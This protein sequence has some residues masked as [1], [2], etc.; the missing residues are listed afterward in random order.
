MEKLEAALA[1]AR[2]AR[3]ASL[4]DD[5]AAPLA[6]RQSEPRAAQGGADW[7]AL[8]ELSITTEQARSGRLG[9]LLGGKDATPY[10]MLRSRTIRLMKDA[11]W[12]R[13]AVTSP[14]AACGKTTVSLNLALSL[15]RQRDLRVMLID[16]DLRRPALH[17][18]IGYQP[19]RSFHEVLEEKANVVE[20][21]VRVG[22]NLIIATN[23]TPS[24]HPAEVLHSDRSR[25]VL[26]AIEAAWQPDIMIFDMS[27][28]LASDDNVG[29]LGN[30]DCSLL[31]VAAESTTLPNIDVCEKEL[32]QLTNVLGVV[33]N[34][35]RYEDPSAGYGYE[36]YE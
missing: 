27:P 11:G 32:A 12:K 2:E 3:K 34:K 8:P 14:N 36:A 4:G 13:L 5:I 26:K 28:M 25:E 35:C 21:C 22:T 33:L 24:R 16:L 29:F 20:A 9:S 18:L 30:V 23:A 17:K 15:A 31:V 1:K 10:D 6:P 7:S 19:A